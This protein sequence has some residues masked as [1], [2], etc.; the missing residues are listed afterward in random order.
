MEIEGLVS[1]KGGRV[2]ETQG[3]AARKGRGLWKLRGR[4]P[5]ENNFL[6]A[7]FRYVYISKAIWDTY[8]F[9][10]HKYYTHSRDKQWGDRVEIWLGETRAHSARTRYERTALE[11]DMSAQR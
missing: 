2:V 6:L 1:R 11:Q 4:F 10:R 3:L 7:L 5:R 8:T 9:S